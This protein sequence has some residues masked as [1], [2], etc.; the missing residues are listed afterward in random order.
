VAS[1]VGILAAVFMGVAADA[2][3]TG[4]TGRYDST[5]AAL[6][7]VY[8]VQLLLLLVTLG[9]FIAWLHRLYSNLR[10]LGADEL[11]FSEGW[12]IGGWFVPVMAWWRP[13]EI[14]NDTWRASDPDLGLHAPRHAWDAAPVPG[15]LLAWWLAYNLWGVMNWVTNRLFIATQDL[16]EERVAA[17]FA[18]ATEA[19][20]IVATLLALR[21]VQMLTRR[22]AERAAARE[23][24]GLSPEPAAQP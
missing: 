20:L 4:I 16:E 19:I 3:E 18:I 12:A 23:R 2:D 24:T 11:R 6:T 10:G 9:F 21:V 15:V 7:I 22:Q 13:K 17:G 1:V 5:A 14:V 8:A